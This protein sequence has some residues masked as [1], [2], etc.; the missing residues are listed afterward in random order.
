[1]IAPQRVP[2]Y[3][4][5]RSR[6]RAKHAKRRR[7]TRAKAQAYAGLGR[8]ALA[9]CVVVLPLMVYVTLTANL[10][11]MHYAVARAE[12][13]RTTLTEETQRLDDRIAQLESRDRLSA[14]AAKLHMHDPQEYAV[15]AL[16]DPAAKPKPK[17]I[18][19]LG[20]MGD[21]FSRP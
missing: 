9:I 15:V 7:S 1:M 2:Q 6:E 20:T 4:I 16:P 12:T 19:F 14:V 11:G 8:V 17:G 21:W 10:T 18:A 3:E 5:P 13:Q